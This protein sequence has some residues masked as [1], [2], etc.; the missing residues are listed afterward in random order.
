MEILVPRASQ[1][2]A[3]SNCLRKGNL[4]A[5]LRQHRHYSIHRR[6]SIA[7]FSLHQC[8]KVATEKRPAFV[9]CL[10]ALLRWPDTQQG[11]R[12]LLG[13]PIVGEVETSGI[14]RSV[15]PHDKGPLEDWL[16][17]AA[18]DAVNKLLQS[19]PPRYADDIL[20]VTQ[21]E[22]AKGFC[23]SF[24]TKAA[25]DDLHGPGQWRHLERFLIAQSCGKQRVIDNARRT[26]H[27]RHTLLG[28][29]ICTTSVDFIAS[30]A[31]MT[32]QALF[33][34][35]THAPEE[36]DWLQLRIGTDDLPDAYR[37]LPVCDDHLRFSIVAIHVGNVGWRFTTLWGLAYGL[38]SAVVAFN[39][40]PQLGVA[41]TRRCLLGLAA[42][43]FDD[44]LSV[45]LIRDADVT[46]RGLQFTFTLMG[47]SPQPSKS[48]APTCNRH[49][50]GTPVHT[51]GA[52][53]RWF[54]TFPTKVY[55]H[56]EDPVPI[57]TYSF[58][59]EPGP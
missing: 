51:G 43:Y 24:M 4:R 52:F 31:R 42:A 59:E 28:E 9:S 55:H 14:F 2:L 41:I 1:Y 3:S 58:R 50:L 47:A 16:G 38:E 45:E 23:S 7:A 11:R 26:G 27:N 57:A 44:E 8:S 15:V 6:R 12:L 17:P 39:R 22:Q 13:Y 36:L 19:G 25:L 30:V 40:F 33:A 46:Q 53:C 56:V 48:F 34:D 21:E 20:R 49:Y 10:T 29:T 35:A 5:P 32:A 37:V 54:C 18:V